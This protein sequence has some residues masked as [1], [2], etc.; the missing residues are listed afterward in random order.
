[1]GVLNINHNRTVRTIVGNKR[2]VSGEFSFSSSYSTGGE[3]GLNKKF[4]GFD[5]LDFIEIEDGEVNTSYD[6]DSEKVKVFLFGDT[7][8]GN[9]AA[10]E[11]PDGEDL[12]TI[13]VVYRSIGT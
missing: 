5:I 13:S 12:S 8:A 4:F 1:M 2:E 7:G 3:T 10:I 6:R 11:A 9:S